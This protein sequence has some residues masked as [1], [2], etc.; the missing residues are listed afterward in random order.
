M[1]CGV[2]GRYRSMSK[3]FLKMIPLYYVVHWIAIS[4]NMLETREVKN[5]LGWNIELFVF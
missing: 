4:Q 5:I 2:G 3:C 1:K